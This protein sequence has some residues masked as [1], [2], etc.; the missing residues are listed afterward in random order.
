VRGKLENLDYNRIWAMLTVSLIG[1]MLPQMLKE[2]FYA[3]PPENK[4]A[5]EPLTTTSLG[6]RMSKYSVVKSEK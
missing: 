1:F 6:L 3:D 2:G 5:V 4:L